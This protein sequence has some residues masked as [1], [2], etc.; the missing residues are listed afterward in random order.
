M[1][2]TLNSHDLH[3]ALRRLPREL[4]QV[5]KSTRYAGRVYVGGGYL[6]AIVAGEPVNDVDV[7]VDS[8]AEAEPLAVL[9]VQL[10]NPELKE[11]KPD[12]ER[13][14]RR[15]HITKNAITIF[16][17]KTTIQI[18]YRWVFSKGPA[19]CGAFDFTC[20]C[21]CF[22]FEDTKWRSY[23]DPRFYQDLAARRL[24]YRAP[25]RNEDAGGSMLR[26]LKYYQKGY[27]MPLDS[28]GAVVA[29]L[30]KGV[31]DI[32][33]MGEDRLAF[34][35]TGLLREV[36]PLIDPEHVAHLGTADEEA[37]L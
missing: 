6:R 21:A 20:C 30:V 19:V 28:L 25:N 4:I 5:M 1:N 35:L 7:F 8:Q 11:A 34:I 13:I 31:E 23:V 33:E 36:D 29:R 18:I 26:V 37:S 16:G 27:R 32:E 9:L 15:M 3:F 22:W 24:V 2:D 17:F 10:R 12:D 14:K